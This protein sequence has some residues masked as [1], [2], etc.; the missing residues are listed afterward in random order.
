[1]GTDENLPGLKVSYALSLHPTNL[2]LKL[3][4]KL[5]QPADDFRVE[6]LFGFF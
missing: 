5:R 4:Q 6:R 3:F 1:M 2:V